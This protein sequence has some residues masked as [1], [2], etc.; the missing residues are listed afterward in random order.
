VNEL[1][2]PRVIAWLESNLSPHRCRHSLG[3]GA[4]ARELAL[5]FGDDPDRCELAGLLHD[6]ARELPAGKMLETARAAG[7]PVDYLEEMAPMPCLHGALG[8]DVAR[9]EFGVADEALLSA[10]AHHTMGR[11]RMT[12][13]EKIVFIAD[14]VEPNRGDAP[15]LRDI[16]E[17]LAVDLDRACRRAYDHT[18]EFLLRT[19]QPIHPEA[20]RGRNW[21]IYCERQRAATS[22]GEMEAPIRG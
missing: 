16:R 10:I 6:A 11:E 18:F 5:R 1:L 14:A 8:A 19:G 3:V 22:D 20:A 21:L 9:A 7:L 17:A 13:T 12:L 15:Y 4:T 2:R